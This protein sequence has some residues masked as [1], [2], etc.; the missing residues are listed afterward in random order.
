MWRI[1]RVLQFGKSA[2]CTQQYKG[3]AADPSTKNVG[4]LCSWYD[5]VPGQ[6]ESSNLSIVGAVNTTLF[7]L[8]YAHSLGI[9]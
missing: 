1:G 9:V 4:I 3:C 6:K 2:E 7:H 8:T 5:S